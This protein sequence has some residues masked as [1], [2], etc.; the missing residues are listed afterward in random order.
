MFD[1]PGLGI[2]TKCLRE[3][4]RFAIRR[5]CCV[6]QHRLG[7]DRPIVLGQALVGPLP[8]AGAWAPEISRPLSRYLAFPTH[9]RDWIL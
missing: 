1:R 8:T 7:A 5:I 4:L 3:E 6:M 2:R 9:G